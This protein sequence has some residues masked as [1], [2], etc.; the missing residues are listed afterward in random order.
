MNKE[1]LIDSGISQI[2]TTSS[3]CKEQH[4]D[5]AVITLAE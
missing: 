1:P 3:V 2:F 5:L 4:T